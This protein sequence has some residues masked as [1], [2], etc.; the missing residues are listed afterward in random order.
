MEILYRSKNAIVVYK[1]PTISAQ[2]DLSGDTDIMTL[3]EEYLAGHGENTRLWLVHR[4]DKVVGGVM[5][6]ARN[7]SAAAEL[8]RIMA[9][10]T[11]VVKRY[12]AITEGKITDGYMEDYIYK[13]SLSSK[14][15]ITD[16]ERK[17]VK[18]CKLYA[19]SL[20]T[21]NHEERELSLVDVEL[22]TGRFHQIR[23]Q[24]SSRKA[25]IVGDKK[26]GSRSRIAKMPALFAYGLEI[27]M[28][29]ET[30]SVK[31]LPDLNSYPW[32]LFADTLRELGDK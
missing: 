31:R 22:Y 18:R 23:A 10:H 6:F 27:K 28:K 24:L 2:S 4:L 1:P 21:V 11:D 19:N 30:I 29:D 16:R 7:P 14:A 9:D 13:D 20:A 25:P 8:S 15:Y 26:Y 3:T 32:S 5:I 17:G 12:Y